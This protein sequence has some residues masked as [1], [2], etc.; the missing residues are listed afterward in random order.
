MEYS[1][2]Y[3]ES[4]HSRKI[5]L[6]TITGETYYDNF[7]TAIVG[8]CTD[9]ESVIEQ[10]YAAFENK[11]DERKRHGELKSNTFKT[12]QFTY[13][14]ASFNKPN[15]EMMEDLLSIIDED[16]YIYF[17]AASKIEYVV[18]QL[19]KDY[20]NSFTTN[21]DAVKY[22]IV[23]AILTYHPEEVIRNIYSTPE[24]FVDSLIT[25]FTEQ[26][27]RNKKN[28]K[29][30]KLENEAFENILSILRD[31]TTPVTL[32][33]DYHM[34]FEGFDSYLK[35][36]GM[37]NY[38]L[39]IDKEGEADENSQTLVAAMD[40]GLKNCSEM[41]SKEHFGL[42][43]ADM[44]AGIIGKMMKSLYHSLHRE[45]NNANVTK[46]LLD[47]KW[48][49]LNDCQ[50]QLYK[51]LYHIVV[52]IDNDWYKIYGGNYSDDLISFLALLDFMNHFNTVDEIKKNLDMQPEYC[53]AYMCY[54]LEEHFQQ[55]VNM[56]PKLSIKPIIP[57]TDE[58]SRNS[59]GARIYF[60]INKQPILKLKEG[61]N[62][63][64]I[65]SV[66]NSK[67]GYPLAT[68]ADDPENICYRL[69][70]QLEGWALTATGMAMMGENMFPAEVIITKIKDNYF[71]N[72]L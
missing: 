48:F 42:R 1:F 37:I 58:Y 65:L 47:K 16:C 43:I 39:V 55:M 26:I 49:L 54:R 10:R 8:W 53:N 69:P 72:I 33:W 27:E 50:L 34:P 5:N 24:Q 51:K 35:S 46:N 11:Y 19:F 7:I 28:I 68:I 14:L 66:G 40:E 67:E 57:E 17:F 64:Y 44:L 32:K 15:T 56:S 70:E 2:Y 9:R 12:N 52:E 21:M 62:R 30:K 23:K 3:D 59:R 4:E 31:A 22:S 36:K 38:R 45:D 13:G 29:L 18:L 20:N 71:A 6:T 60:D 63:L 41:N 61:Q 25:F